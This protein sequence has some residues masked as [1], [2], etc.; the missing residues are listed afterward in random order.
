MTESA[1]R[2]AAMDA[3]R[4]LTLRGRDG[5]RLAGLSR[6]VAS[7]RGRVL[8]LHGYADHK[9]RYGHVSDAL[10]AAGYDVHLYDAR[11]HGH[12]DGLRGYVARF[13]AYHDDLDEV[14]ATLK[15]ED[16]RTD[17][18]RAALPFF[19]VG[20]SMGGLVALTYAL[21]RPTAFKGVAVSSPFLGLRIKVPALKLWA[22]RLV[23]A[24]WPTLL[25][26]GEIN[27]GYLSHDAKVGQAYLDDPLVFKTVNPRWFTE[28]EAAQRDL[29]DR[30]AALVTPH[31]VM[32]AGD[33]MI[34]D[35]AASKAVFERTGATDKTF[36]MYD[37]RY[38]E[39]FNEID[40]ERVLGDLVQWLDE[41]TAQPPPV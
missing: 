2:L 33:D 38:H 19:L 15:A 29:H 40:K 27:A 35:P 24:V 20:H 7:S 25:M 32:Q 5:T 28:A 12:S 39:L 1:A 37:D 36:R 21:R 22:G 11:G 3:A 16:E 4:P 6:R 10:A 31:L 18:R 13:S 17:E 26:T 23:S 34:A 9:G 14:A 8:V 30:A 41:R